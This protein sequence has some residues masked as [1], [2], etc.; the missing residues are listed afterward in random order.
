MFH[1]VPTIS[2]RRVASIRIAKIN[3]EK[4]RANEIASK[5]K[6]KKI[7]VSSPRKTR[8]FKT[9]RLTPALIRPNQFR[10][11]ERRKQNNKQD[12]MPE[13]NLQYRFFCRGFHR[14]SGQKT[15]P[16]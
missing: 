13:L 3:V 4:P 6:R 5:S 16:T 8:I 14:D 2:V 10:S 1:Y 7:V 12:S 11:A 15:S 9:N